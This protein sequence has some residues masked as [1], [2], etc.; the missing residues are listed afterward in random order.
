ML[1]ADLSLARKLERA[2]ARGNAGFV[3]VR[4][5]VAPEVGAQWI[6]VAGAYAMF[7]GPDSFLTQTF[8]LGLF[9]DVTP[10]H[11]D[12]LESFFRER[13]APVLHEI[14]PLA[15][16]GLLPLLTGRGYQPLEYTTVLYKALAPGS[17]SAAGN[18]RPQIRLAGPDEAELWARTAADG[19]RSEGP[20]L[21]DFIFEFGKISTQRA[22]SFLAEIDGRAVATGSLIL[23]EDVALLAGAS[24]VPDARGQGAQT[25]LLHARLRYAAEQG[26]TVATIGALPG[27]QSQRNA[28]KQGFRVAY[29]RTK[30]QLLR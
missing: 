25:A 18:D 19:W 1:H 22:L 17:P 27:S 6:E 28:E 5:R 9:E 26:C 16:P 2:E 20:E 8:G 21:A 29:T 15:S 10:A 23:H 12:E 4:A 30:W 11:L 13:Q 7:D 3:E 24:T 14:S